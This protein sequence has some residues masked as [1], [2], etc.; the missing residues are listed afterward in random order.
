MSIFVLLLEDEIMMMSVLFLITR[1][2]TYLDYEPNGSFLI[3]NAVCLQEK[4]RS[5]A[6]NL[7]KSADEKLWLFMY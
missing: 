4:Q 7:S 1:F 3:L 2:Y 6:D 5:W